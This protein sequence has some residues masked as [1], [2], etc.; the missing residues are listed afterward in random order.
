MYSVVL[1]LDLDLGR[2]L[3]LELDHQTDSRPQ[4]DAILQ[5][6]RGLMS[7]TVQWAVEVQGIRI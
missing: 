3:P 7:G 5:L 2:D 6:V 4:R 1:V